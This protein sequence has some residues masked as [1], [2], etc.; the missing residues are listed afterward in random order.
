MLNFVFISVYF[1]VNFHLDSYKISTGKEGDS[2]AKYHQEYFVTF[3]SS[4][5][6]LLSIFQEGE[7]MLIQIYVDDRI[8]LKS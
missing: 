1:P 2:G 4:F 6:I 8:M 7:L 3:Y 5:F